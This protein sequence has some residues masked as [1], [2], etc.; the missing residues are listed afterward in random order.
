MLPYD[1]MASGNVRL[2]SGPPI[3]RYVSQRLTAGGSTS[4]NVEPLGSHRLSTMRTL[5]LRGSKTIRFGNR[6][7]ELNVDVYNLT[8]ANTVW[9]VRSLTGRTTVRQSGDRNGALLTF[10][11]FMSPSQIL[12]PRIVRLTASFRF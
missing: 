2:Q 9:G 11:Q 1:I 12:A 4:V 7:A 10:P 6:S 3:T 8:N 5:D